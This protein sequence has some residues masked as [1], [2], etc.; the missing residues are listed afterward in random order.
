MARSRDLGGPA[1][2]ASCA[3][4]A[5]ALVIPFGD[6]DAELGR[7]PR[8]ML[9]SWVRWRTRRSRVP[10]QRQRVPFALRRRERE[11]CTPSAFGLLRGK[12][13]VDLPRAKGSTI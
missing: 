7:S 2:P 3:D 6:G 13:E 4:D 5:R 11:P 8:I 10:M 9:M 12:A 1:S